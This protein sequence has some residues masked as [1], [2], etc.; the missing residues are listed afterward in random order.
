MYGRACRHDLA[1]SLWRPGSVD[2][3][4]PGVN[5]EVGRCHA[6]E[7]ELDRQGTGRADHHGR[8]P[9]TQKQ[10][11]LP[12]ILAMETFWCQG[13][14]EPDAGSDLARLR[15]RPFRTVTIG[16]STARRS[17]PA[18][19]PRRTTAC[20]SRAPAVVSDK[21]R[22]LLMF[23]VPWTRRASAW[24][25]SSRSTTRNPLPRSS[26]TT[27]SC[28]T[29]H[30]WARPT[31]AGAPRSGCCLSSARPTAC[32][33]PGASIANCGSSCG[34]ASPTRDCPAAGRR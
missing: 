11:F 20:C 12:A 7:R 21:H 1:Q 26:S 34:P 32:T 16:A 3:R 15:T 33:A 5:K 2:R 6:G 9:R 25:R 4:A 23:A 30:V 19:L 22:G 29:A 31:R 13:F 28:P 18:V 8:R 27:W 24:C 17:G 14:S 10:L